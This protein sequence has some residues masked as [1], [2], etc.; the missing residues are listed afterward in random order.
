METKGVSRFIY[1]SA[2]NVKDS[3]RNA[4]FLI[5]ILA[6]TILRTETT[7][8]EV[9]EKIIRQSRL[10][11]TLVRSA[12]LTNGGHTANYRYGE[13]VKAKGIA[14]SISRADVADF[15][16]RQLTDNTFLRKTPSVM[17]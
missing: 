6:T 11:W 8:H 5:K 2:I 1:M 15:I 17:Y 4:G 7:G 10:D 16:L 3:R 13:D 12:G 9:R 14:A